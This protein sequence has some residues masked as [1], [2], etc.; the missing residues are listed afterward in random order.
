MKWRTQRQLLIFIIMLSLCLSFC[1]FNAYAK[2]KYYD[3][4]ESYNDSYLKDDVV[5]E[6]SSLIFF[7]PFP[8]SE[9]KNYI[10][11][12]SQGDYYLV[13]TNDK[14]INFYGNSMVAEGH[15][16]V[17]QF[18]QHNRQWVFNDDYTKY[19]PANK[20]GFYKQFKDYTIIDSSISTDSGS[21]IEQN[22]YTAK[23]GYRFYWQFITVEKFIIKQIESISDYVLTNKILTYIVLGGFA[24]EI[25]FFVV[26][27][28]RRVGELRCDEEMSSDSD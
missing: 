28:I 18:A 24:A 5:D 20:Y 10:I 11:L 27:L 25:L 7:P 1:N 2:S 3:D 14:R 22:K 12:S 26:K 19:Y 16:I 21:Q 13:L 8:D 9:Y 4:G 17:Y 15:F 6:D 23:T